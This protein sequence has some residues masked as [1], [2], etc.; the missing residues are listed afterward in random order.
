MCSH[1]TRGSDDD[2]L[3]GAYN[4]DLGTI[5]LKLRRATGFVT[6]TFSPKTPLSTGLVHERNG[7]S[8]GASHRVACVFMGFNELDTSLKL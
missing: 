4:D 8:N 5:E 3:P 1:N 7:K 2:D 6:K